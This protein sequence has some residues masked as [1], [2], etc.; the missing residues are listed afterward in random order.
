MKKILYSF[1]ALIT[2]SIVGCDKDEINP[3]DG[4]F[5]GDS[6]TA[7][8]NFVEDETTGD[9]TTAISGCGGDTFVTLP[10]SLTLPPTDVY[11]NPSNSSGLTVNYTI[12]DVE[13]S[14]AGLIEQQGSVVIPAG[15][16]SADIVI[17]FPDNLTNTLEFLVTVTDVSRDNIYFGNAENTGE[18]ARTV[19]IVTGNDIF[20]GPLAVEEQQVGDPQVYN[21]TSIATSGANTNEIVVSNIYGENSE[22]QTT[23]ILNPDGTVSFKPILEN[24]LFSNSSVGNIYFNGISGTYSACDGTINI[25]GELRYGPGQASSIGP[26][27]F[28]FTK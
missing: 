17:N 20:L 18:V 19:R 6:D 26:I 4:R 8:L 27:N 12:V 3:N 11:S 7:I 5:G 24:F 28:T 21:Y 10:I 1:L 22:S 2:L 9:V 23:F 15:E 16:L 25:V 13:G 14:S